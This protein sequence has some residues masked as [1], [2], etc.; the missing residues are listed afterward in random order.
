[1]LPQPRVPIRPSVSQRKLA[2]HEVRRILRQRIL[3]G[4]CEGGTKLIQGKLAKDFGVSIGVVREALVE[5][6]AWGLV[7][8]K[9][10]HGVTVREWNLERMLESYDIREMLEGLSA[11]LACGHLDSAVHDQLHELAEKIYDASLK[12]DWEESCRLDREFHHRILQLSD[13]RTLQRLTDN[14]LFLGKMVWWGRPGSVPVE[15]FRAHLEIL[16]AIHLN[17]PQEA[18]H[19]AREHVAIARRSIAEM[20]AKGVFEPHWL[21]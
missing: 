4:Q 13:N 8:T 1:V 10:N 5:L 7:E 11:R 15:T 14:Y 17:H 3:D 2:R 9:D 12:D 16:N 18:E 21:T 6:E 20:A 19:A